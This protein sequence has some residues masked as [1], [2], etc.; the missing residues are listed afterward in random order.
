MPPLALWGP[1]V[2]RGR[3]EQPDQPALLDIPARQAQ[4]ALLVLPAPL[5]LPA[6]QA[7]QAQ[8]ALLALPAFQV[9]LDR[10]ARKD[11]PA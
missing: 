7:R 4:A 6:R 3:L 1:R 11:Q 5:D 10:P 9:L 2:R 8:P